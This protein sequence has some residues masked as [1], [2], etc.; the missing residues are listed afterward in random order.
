MAELQ[1]GTVKWFNDEK[2]TDL[3]NPTTET[4]MYSYT[5]VKSTRQHPVAFPSKTDKKLLSKSVKAK[6]ALR[7]RT[8]PPSN[9]ALR[10]GQAY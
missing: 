5:S 8:L 9:H 10:V 6:K 7:L 1:N 3:S 2:A 4:A